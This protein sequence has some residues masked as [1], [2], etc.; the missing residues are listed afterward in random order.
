MSLREVTSELDGNL[1]RLAEKLRSNLRISILT[2]AGISAA[3]GIPTFRGQEG[4]WKKYRPEDLATLD[5]FDTNPVLVWKW[6]AWRRERIVTSQPNRGHHVLA[7]WSE[8]INSF[9]LI[10]QN[11]DGL[12]ERAGTHGV[13]RFHGSIWELQCRNKCPDSPDSWWDDTV[14]F[15][16]IPPTCPYC[17]GLARPGVTWFGE[18]ID[19]EILRQSLSATDCDIFFAIGTSAIV[20]PAAN[21]IRQA[22][23]NGAFT[24]EINVDATPASDL[25]DLAFHG[26]AATI[27]EQIEQRLTRCP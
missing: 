24:I 15:R 16:S 8:R 7:T 22:K 25:V 11:V 6:Y 13:I 26:P 3:S 5:A 14:P 20:N 23:Q 21:L 27:L 17:H 1:N 10:T 9:C 2:G 18:S 19:H 12:H 4:L